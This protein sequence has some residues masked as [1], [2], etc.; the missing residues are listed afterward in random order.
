MSLFLMETQLGYTHLHPCIPNIKYIASEL[1]HQ[2]KVL[3]Q[4][5]DLR[6]TSRIHMVGENLLLYI[7]LLSLY[8]YITHTYIHKQKLIK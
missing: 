7:L 8:T 3:A 2:V 6:L 4:P 5:D 1:A